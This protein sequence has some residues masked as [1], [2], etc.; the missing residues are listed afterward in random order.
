MHKLSMPIFYTQ[1][2]IAIPNALWVSVCARAASN[3][4]FNN[5]VVVVCIHSKYQYMYDC[6]CM[7][8]AC[9]AECMHWMWLR[10]VV[11]ALR[12]AIT[13]FRTIRLNHRLF[14][15]FAPIVLLF[16]FCR[17]SFSSSSSCCCHF[18]FV[19]FFVHWSISIADIIL[20]LDYSF[21]AVHL[22]LCQ[23]RLLAHMGI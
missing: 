18:A 8:Y 20:Y 21:L 23:V 9:C 22:F 16:C 11:H 19:L 15:P 5:D 17:G 12:F 2:T 6:K 4:F 3:R 10:C 14:W 13:I 1:H 7:P